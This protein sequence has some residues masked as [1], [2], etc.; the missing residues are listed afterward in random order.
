MSRLSDLPEP[1]VE[2]VGLLNGGLFPD[3]NEGLV[4]AR[5]VPI[6]VLDLTEDQWTPLREVLT[7]GAAHYEAEYVIGYTDDMWELRMSMIEPHFLEFVVRLSRDDHRD[8]LKQVYETKTLALA[9]G[10]TDNPAMLQ[11][12]LLEFDAG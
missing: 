5:D 2:H 8:F 7:M 12:M 9:H 6:L 3:Q 4:T 10:V 11:S 1:R